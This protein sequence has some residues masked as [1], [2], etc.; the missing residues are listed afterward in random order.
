MATLI[1]IAFACPSWA[2]NESAGGAWAFSTTG[3]GARAMGMGGAFVAVSDDAT[4]AYWNPAGLGMLEQWELTSMVIEAN[5]D[6]YSLTGG[7][8]RTHQYLSGILPTRIGRFSLSGNYFSI[9]DIQHTTGTSEFDFERHEYF[10][11]NEWALTV[12]AGFSLPN[13]KSPDSSWLF[14]GGNIRIMRQSFFQLS[15]TGLGGD[16]GLS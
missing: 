15:T 3:M 7:F 8:P 6:I 16:L 4:A 2:M 13:L 1:S 10:N 11:D 9:R 12:S 5:H 14:L